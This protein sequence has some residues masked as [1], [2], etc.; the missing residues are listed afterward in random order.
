M[1]Y[2]SIL[3]RHKESFA[4]MILRDE[5]YVAP[6]G[7]SSNTHMF[8]FGRHPLVSMAHLTNTCMSLMRTMRHF[9][10]FEVSFKTISDH[11]DWNF[12]RSSKPYFL[13]HFEWFSNCFCQCSSINTFWYN[14][15]KALLRYLSVSWSK[16]LN[17]NYTV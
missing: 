4:S 12:Q 14:E 16:T 7:Y 1:L 3:T 5:W 9:I 6:S 10:P 2:T 11:S 17:L 13:E 8:V 15:E